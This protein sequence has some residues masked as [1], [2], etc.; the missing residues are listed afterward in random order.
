MQSVP[1]K[2]TS[3]SSKLSYREHRL[4]H[5]DDE[6]VLCLCSIVLLH[7]IEMAN[8]TLTR[9]EGLGPPHVVST[10][11]PQCLKFPPL[12]YM[13]FPKVECGV[14]FYSCAISACFEL[15]AIEKRYC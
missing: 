4:R 13:S 5:A 7:L 3:K 10:Y 15:V 8:I 11:E 14:I 2:L 1:R 9:Y 12:V 6:A